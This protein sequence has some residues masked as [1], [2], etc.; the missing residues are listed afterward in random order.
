[1]RA[2][3]DVNAKDNDG[4]TAL[5][6]AAANSN[7]D[8][9][10]VLLKAGADVDEKDER[11]WTALMTAAA[12]NTGPEIVSV[13]LRAGADPNAEG[14]DGRTA[15]MM[16]EENE[17]PEARTAIVELLKNRGAAT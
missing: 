17:D 5:L 1:M 3:A 6:A 11:G 15:L 4:W 10:S 12:T 7:P 16:T 14:E 13:L 8:I 9:V 2:G